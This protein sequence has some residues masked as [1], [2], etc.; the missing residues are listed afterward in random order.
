MSENQV[1]EQVMMSPAQAAEHDV[2]ERRV[3]RQLDGAAKAAV[4]VR[5]LLNEGAEL[6]IESLPDD[7]QARLTAQMGEMGLIDRVTLAS[8]VHEFAEALDSIGLSFPKGLAGALDAMDGRI[9]PQTAAR[10]RKEAGVRQIGDPWGRLAALPVKDLVPF[11]EREST[12]IA[13]VL[14]AK[15]DVAKAAELLGQLPGPLARRITYAMSL[16]GK[17]SPEAVD[18][19][20]LSLAAQMDQQPLMAFSDQPGERLGAILN[21][22]TASTRDDMLEGLEQTDED[23]AADVRKSIFTF[24]HIPARLSPRDVPSVL[25]AADQTDVVR[26]IAA[27]PDLDQQDVVDFLLANMSSRMADQLREEAQEIGKVKPAEGEAAMTAI[28]GALRQLQAD[29]EITLLTP[30]EEDEE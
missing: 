1:I 26:A 9:S 27:A 22:S 10:L 19:I 30:E 13:A 23:F 18:R 4:V 11:M 24:A 16:T 15:L 6:P 5:L 7:L 25:R 17:V 14:M 8:V 28:I 12:E 20:G 21:Q 3:P 29:G 2:Q